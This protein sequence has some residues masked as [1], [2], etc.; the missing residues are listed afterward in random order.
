MTLLN[1]ELE[2][3]VD[4]QGTTVIVGATARSMHPTSRHRPNFDQAAVKRRHEALRRRPRSL[5]VA[6]FLL[7]ISG[8]LCPSVSACDEALILPLG[9]AI[10]W[11]S[12][13]FELRAVQ[14]HHAAPAISDRAQRF[15]LGNQSA[16][17][18]AP[19]TQHQREILVRQRKLI[20]AHPVV[21]H[22]KPAS[23]TLAGAEACVCGSRLADLNQESLDIEQKAVLNLWPSHRD[24]LEVLSREA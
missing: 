14:Q 4:T 9:S 1:D 5:R 21:S 13:L 20:P 24:A 6:A 22:Q 10:G 18:G 19:R 16:D 7:L 15:K 3:P 8:P 2:W 23:E 17:C 12:D 11:T